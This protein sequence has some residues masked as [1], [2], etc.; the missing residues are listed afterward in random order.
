MTIEKPAKAKVAFV[1]GPTGFIGE[2]LVRRLVNDGWEVHCLV[3]GASDTSRLPE[4]AKQHRLTE[5]SAVSR[6][7]QIFA[8]IDN[9]GPDIVF[10]LASLYLASHD[11]HEIEGL[12]ASNILL[13]AELA[14]AMAMSQTRRIISTGTAWQRYEIK[15]VGEYN[16][17]NLYAATKQA[18]ASILKYYTEACGLSLIT[19][20]LFDTYGPGDPRRKLVKLLSDAA[21]S[22][23]RL[24]MSPGEQI[25]DL[26]HVDDVVEAYIIAALRLSEM[27]SPIYERY[28]ISGTRLKVRDLVDLVAEALGRPLSVDL[29]ALPYRTREVMEPVTPSEL[30]R[31][32]GWKPSR[33]LRATLPE[34]LCD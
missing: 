14:E 13:A 3:R 22:G 32:P 6:V 4:S 30:E 16:P 31:L 29:G 26:T 8:T 1:T 21:V 12:I 11:P 28:L 25:I 27:P 20:E 19:L 24:N 7:E 33:D 10:H 15:E 18:S 34:L 17:V 23:E 9:T 2:R 5:D